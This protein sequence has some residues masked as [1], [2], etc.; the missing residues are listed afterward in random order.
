MKTKILYIPDSKSMNFDQSIVTFFDK[1]CDWEVEMFDLFNVIIP[2]IERLTDKVNR[3]EYEM[4]IGVGTGALM[5]KMLDKKIPRIYIDPLTETEHLW[6]LRHKREYKEF[7]EF[8][9]MMAELPKIKAKQITAFTPYNRYR[10]GSS[11]SGLT[12]TDPNLFRTVSNGKVITNGWFEE[13]LAA[14]M[15]KVGYKVAI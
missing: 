15:K 10:K 7:D 6:D 2:Q 14:A 8:T 9:R 4:I 1:Y 13:L 5:A 11:K 3:G 12:I